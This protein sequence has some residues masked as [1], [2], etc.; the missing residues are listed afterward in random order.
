MKRSTPFLISLL[1]ICA[2]SLTTFAQGTTSRVTGTVLDQ[3]GGAV[4]GATV[5]LTNEASGVSFTTQTNENG[6]YG[7][8]LVQA[9]NYSI[10]IEKQGFK[11]YLSKGNAP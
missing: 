1:L 10:A 9:G 7:F 11:R 8:D 3:N 5:T 6:N 4:V 2:F